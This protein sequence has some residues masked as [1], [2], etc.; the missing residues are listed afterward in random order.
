MFAGEEADDALSF[1]R[2]DEIR[3]RLRIILRLTTPK[4]KSRLLYGLVGLPKKG[5]HCRTREELQKLDTFLRLHFPTELAND[6]SIT[7]QDMEVKLRELDGDVSSELMSSSS[8]KRAPGGKPFVS[9]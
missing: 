8:H 2:K 3:Q 9:L 4:Q 7:L 6:T 1:E 5:F